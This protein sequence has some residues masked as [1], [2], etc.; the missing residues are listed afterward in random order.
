MICSFD[1]SVNRCGKA[2]KVRSPHNLT[3]IAKEITATPDNYTSPSRGSKS[4]QT[5]P[6][7]ERKPPTQRKDQDFWT[8]AIIPVVILALI[9][10]CGCV[11][12]Y[13]TGHANDCFWYCRSDAEKGSGALDADGAEEPPSK[14]GIISIP[15]SL[16]LLLKEGDS[17]IP[18]C[19]CEMDSKKDGAQEK[20][21]NLATCTPCTLEAM[22]QELREP[23]PKEG[24]PEVLT[25]SCEMDMKK[26]GAQEQLGLFDTCTPCTLETMS[27]ELGEPLPKEGDSGILT[28]SSEKATKKGIAKCFCLELSKNTEHVQVHI[29]ILKGIDKCIKGI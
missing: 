24:D 5:E 16:E 1:T 26:D 20:L 8:A 17:E 7:T 3:T 18:T 9:A 11:Y 13:K 15:E 2:T 14:I 28:R 21:A 27:E 12:I 4:E 23:L 25:C 29:L 22:S 10:I 19:S 6:P